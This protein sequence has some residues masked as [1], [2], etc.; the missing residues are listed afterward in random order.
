LPCIGSVGPQNQSGMGAG[1]L[2][3]GQQGG[4]TY[5]PNS[6]PP[7][8]HAQWHGSL[9]AIGW[10]HSKILYVGNMG[11]ILIPHTRSHPGPMPLHHPACRVG[12]E[13]YPE[14]PALD[15]EIGQ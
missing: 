7:T 10:L 4:G 11:S 5:Q 8:L 9:L 12:W 1:K 13:D 3:P 14:A 2:E 6:G 15:I